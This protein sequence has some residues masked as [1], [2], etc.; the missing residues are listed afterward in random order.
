[1]GRMK[2]KRSD[3]A[4]AAATGA[5]TVS[6]GAFGADVPTAAE[7]VLVARRACDVAGRNVPRYENVSDALRMRRKNG[8]SPICFNTMFAVDL[9]GLEVSTGG[10]GVFRADVAGVEGGFVVLGGIGLSIGD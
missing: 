9:A 10:A 5:P 3:F 1:M 4:V 2:A 6:V 8:S 7:G